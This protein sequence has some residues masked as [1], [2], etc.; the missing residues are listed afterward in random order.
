MRPPAVAGG[1]ARGFGRQRPTLLQKPPGL[2][3]DVPVELVRPRASEVDRTV[4]RPPVLTRARVRSIQEGEIGPPRIGD[5]PRL[6]GVAFAP[7]SRQLEP[8]IVARRGK[9]R[10]RHVAGICAGA[11]RFSE[12]ASM[13]ADDRPGPTILEHPHLREQREDGARLPAERG[14][15]RNRAREA[16]PGERSRHDRRRPAVT[17]RDCRRRQVRDE[18]HQRERIARGERLLEQQVKRGV[19]R[20]REHEHRERPGRAQGERDRAGRRQGEDHARERRRFPGT[21]ERVEEGVERHARGGMCPEHHDA[22]EVFA[23]LAAQCAQV[24]RRPAAQQDERNRPDRDAS[25]DAS[26]DRQAPLPGR[27]EHVREQRQRQ[28]RHLR[29]D[30]DRKSHEKPTGKSNDARRSR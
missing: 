28:D 15:R 1:D 29:S 27:E 13:H 10:P 18:R 22:R 2:A 30:T 14:A 6:P 24:S 9:Q 7:R 19:R 21:H 16:E 8:F 26:G 23:R 5:E 3:E 17:V 25:R 20:E 11:P 12:H 4:Q